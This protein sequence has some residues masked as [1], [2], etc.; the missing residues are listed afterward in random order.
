MVIDIPDELVGWVIA[1]IVGGLVLLI[2]AWA[3][4]REHKHKRTNSLSQ[5]NGNDDERVESTSSL[6]FGSIPVCS[7]AL[8]SMFAQTFRSPSPIS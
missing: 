7:C 6:P 5:G 1:M 3:A 4:H 8:T 2:W